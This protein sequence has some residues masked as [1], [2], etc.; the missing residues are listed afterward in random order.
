MNARATAERGGLA[1]AALGDEGS[2]GGLALI[3]IRL[4]PASTAS[5]VQDAWVSLF[6]AGLVILT[7]GAAEALGDR[8]WADHAP[9]T[10][11]LPL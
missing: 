2:I 8:R 5:E 7:P 11:V 3:G 6:D 10:V 1:V 4:C 9:L